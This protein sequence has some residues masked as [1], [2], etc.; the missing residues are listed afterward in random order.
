MD[1]KH[2]AAM[3]LMSRKTKED[4]VAFLDKMMKDL[5]FERI[6][7]VLEDHEGKLGKDLEKLRAQ[8][9]GLGADSISAVAGLEVN[10][11]EILSEKRYFEKFMN[12]LIPGSIPKKKL[13]E[14]EELLASISKSQEAAA[15]PEKKEE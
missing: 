11:E 15:P 3:M 14:T 2:E 9:F 13:L 8:S 12:L 4:Q 6:G 1:F 7:S 10:R 5:A